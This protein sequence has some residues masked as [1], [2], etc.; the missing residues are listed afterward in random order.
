VTFAEPVK[1]EFTYDE[2][3]LGETPE[4]FL[5]IV[6]Q[7]DDLSWNAMLKSVVDPA[8]KT[9]T[10]E[11]SHFSDWALGRFID[12]S[13]TPKS[14][15]LLKGKTVDLRVSGF[16]RDQAA[17]DEDLAPLIPITGNGDELTPLT[18][19]P[20]VESRFMNF[21]VKRW[22]LNGTPAPVSNDN[23]A[24]S[25]TGVA[26][27]FT[28]PNKKP[29]ANPVAVTVEL[30]ANNKEG[31]KSAYMLTSNI[32]IVDSDYFLLVNIDGVVYEYYQY[33]FNGTIPPD[34]ND[35][36]M[37]NCGYSEDDGLSMI[38]V[39]SVNS[40]DLK[41][42]FALVV[43]QPSESTLTLNCFSNEG[44]DEVEFIPAPL[45]P[46]YQLGFENRSLVNSVCNRET[47]CTEF[48]L[49][50]L[51]YS[52]THL[53]EVYGD[54]SGIL[55]EDPVGYSF[56]CKSTVPHTVSGQFRLVMVR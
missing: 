6:T 29:A 17:E 8:T 37:A 11:A 50:L 46:T 27:K 53:S 42:S 28:A 34:P 18:P 51:E 47:G 44:D 43:S 49:T 9:V 55:H 36:S 33:G 31:G 2:F 38:G 56:D 15:T 23:G 39:H 21:K 41:E 32:S 20:P 7:S 24:L 54:F 26:A 1:L 48:T 16:V 13:L 10:V 3:L 5:W 52:G 14:V 45:T 30:E 22:T 4:D 12:L 25:G 19:I 40:T 35:I